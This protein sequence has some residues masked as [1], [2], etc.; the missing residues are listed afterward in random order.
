MVPRSQ[1]ITFWFPASLILSA[2][3]TITYQ[4][5]SHQ[6]IW[7]KKTSDVKHEWNVEISVWSIEYMVVCHAIVNNSIDYRVMRWRV[8]H[9]NVSI[10][11]CVLR[12]TSAVWSSK[13]KLII[14]GNSQIFTLQKSSKWNLPILYP[15]LIM[16]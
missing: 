6:K 9:T 4:I 2:E 8:A 10:R 14:E 3:F 5:R 7:Q 11:W 13:T 12:R 1:T 16:L 15:V